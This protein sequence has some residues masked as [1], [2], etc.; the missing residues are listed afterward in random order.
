VLKLTGLDILFAA[1]G[2]LYL[3]LALVGVC[4]ALW[5]GKT[6]LRKGIYAVLVLAAFSAPLVPEV[7]RQIEFRNR[8]ATAKSMFEERCR[9]AGEK[10]YKTVENV[11]GIYLMKVRTSTNFGNQFELDDPY[12][13]D[14]TGDQYLLNFL[15]GYYHQRNEKPVVGSPAHTGF[16]YIEAMDPKD[17]KRYRYT[18]GL[19]VVGQMKIEPANLQKALKIDPKY[20]INNYAF[21]LDKAPAPGEPPR[22]GV[23]YDDI[24]THEEREYW[25]AGSSLKVVDLETNEVIAERIGYMMDWAQGSGAGQRSPWL[26]AADNAC[27]GFQWTSNVPVRNGAGE[28]AGQ[29]LVFVEKVLSPSK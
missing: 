27:P 16:H 3:L 14:S 13:H 26:F 5:K 4:I 6:W 10:I 28:Q 8:Q 21:V 9:T 24:S 15:Q 1:A 20:D 23:T 12:G 19:K 29:T 17:G 25:I 2:N 18:G 22:Y 7:T 11:E